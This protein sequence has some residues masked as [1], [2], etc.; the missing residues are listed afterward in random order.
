MLGLIDTMLRLLDST[1]TGKPLP[2]HR[3]LVSSSSACLFTIDKVCQSVCAAATVIL[4][5][6]GFALLH[7][8]WEG[9]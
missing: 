6:W 4:G 5:Y 2:N 9:G 7:R 3:T 8:W 1:S